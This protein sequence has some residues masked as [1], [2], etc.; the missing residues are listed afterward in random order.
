MHL[1]LPH[2]GCGS[3]HQE[4]SDRVAVH[5]PHLLSLHP[6]LLRSL[7]WS[8]G[9]DLQQCA[10]STAQRSLST[11]TVFIIWSAVSFYTPQD[12]SWHLAYSLILLLLF[13]S[14]AAPHPPTHDLTCPVC[15]LPP[16]ALWQLQQAAWL[17]DSS[18]T[19]EGL[20]A[21]HWGRWGYLSALIYH[22]N[23]PILSQN[24]EMDSPTLLH[25]W[26]MLLICITFGIS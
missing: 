16:E 21:P 17:R 8:P 14:H 9:Q 4:L 2:L 24:N 18:G 1:L 26:T 19:P 7:L 12:Q 23:P 11:H 13:S 10:R 3:L 25:L 20:S 5:Q 22:K 6:D 15:F